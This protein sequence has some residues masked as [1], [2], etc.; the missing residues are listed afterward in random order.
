MSFQSIVIDY[1]EHLDPELVT[2]AAYK[3]NITLKEM[4]WQM[5]DA[6]DAITNAL[7][8][9]YTSSNKKI[10]MLYLDGPPGQAKSFAAE[11]ALTM[12]TKYYNDIASTEYT[13]NYMNIFNDTPISA[14]VGKSVG[15]LVF[16][17]GIN[18]INTDL[19][20]LNMHIA[21]I[22]DDLPLSEMGNIPTALVN[23]R[24]NIT[25]GGNS[26]IVAKDDG[27]TIYDAKVIHKTRLIIC[28]TNVDIKALQ[29]KGN[30]VIN[31]VIDRFDYG[32]TIANKIKWTDS[33][34]I[35][36][37]LKKASKY[38]A[39]KMKKFCSIVYKTGGIMQA[40]PRSVVAAWDI[41]NMQGLEGL[42]GLQ[43][44]NLDNEEIKKLIGTKI[45]AIQVA[46]NAAA[47]EYVEKSLKNIYEN[48][49]IIYDA[50]ETMKLMLQVETLQT[51]TL[52][53]KPN[54]PIENDKRNNISHALSVLR[55][56]LNKR[57]NMYKEEYTKDMRNE[58]DK[59]LN[60]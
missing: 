12:F 38:D 37:L 56:T 29:S 32:I 51:L 9:A 15:D 48:V 30:Q 33:S 42:L 44:A 8:R 7:I 50:I 39:D 41:Y 60:S 45:D 28:C 11:Q 27:N 6:V 3:V 10:T 20:M 13:Y 36:D 24:T 53:I 34:L 54:A 52:S 40:T 57:Y 23:I 55:D 14:F 31:S 22:I 18:A 16:S 59:K 5:D 58:F 46:N 2:E 26:Y 35:I 21:V 49:K 25:M 4:L 17:K 43:I 47:L 19:G 1:R